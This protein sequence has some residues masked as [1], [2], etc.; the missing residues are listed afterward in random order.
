YSLRA[1]PRF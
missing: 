1:R